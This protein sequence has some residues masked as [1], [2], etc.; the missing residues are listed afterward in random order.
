MRCMHEGQMHE[1]NCFLT[2]TYDQAH[3]P[4]DG[5]LDIGAWQN[6]AKRWRNKRGTFRYF[7]CG[8]YGEQN[9]RPHYH[10]AIF[11]EDFKADRVLD[12][13]TPAGFPLYTSQELTD[14]W[15]HGRAWI[16]ELT[17]E[18]A[19]YVARYIMKKVTGPNSS[20]H[21]EREGL[22]HE[23]E[24]TELLPEYTTMSRRPGIGTTWFEKFH[25]DVYPSDE[26]II[27]GKSA[28]PPSF[29]DKKLERTEPETHHLVVTRRKAKARKERRQKD[30][31][32]ERLDVRE[33]V[34]LAEIKHF[35]RNL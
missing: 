30:Q 23:G 19:A 24:I 33:Q 22:Q 27:N 28:V 14:L 21:Y 1:H 4:R 15:T 18:S 31:T 2:L 9:G 13:T 29:Y 32:E 10:A 26:V 11:G 34:K 16:G 8:E 35:T 5:S 17:F 7:H 25:T 3:L 12:K 20:A 6:F